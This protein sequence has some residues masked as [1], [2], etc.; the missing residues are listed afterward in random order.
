MDIGEALV[1]FLVILVAVIVGMWIYNY[2][3]AHAPAKA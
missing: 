3:E 2:A 1:S